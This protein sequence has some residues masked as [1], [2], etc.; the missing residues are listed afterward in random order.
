[1]EYKKII[2]FKGNDVLAVFSIPE[3]DLVVLPKDM[4]DIE[5]I[6][7]PLNQAINKGDKIEIKEGKVSLLKEPV[8]KEVKKPWYWPF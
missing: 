6:E 1:M 7:I 8:K 4:M 3:T 5:K 2:I